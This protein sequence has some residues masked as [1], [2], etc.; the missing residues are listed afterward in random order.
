MKLNA[1]DYKITGMVLRESRP[2][3]FGN[4]SQEFEIKVQ[5]KV[6][7]PNN[8]YYILSRVLYSDGTIR[9]SMDWQYGKMEELFEGNFIET[10][11]P[12]YKEHLK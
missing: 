12:Y 5:N 8:T 2:F 6:G 1:T 9:W 10:F 4:S 11:E 7:T 3:L